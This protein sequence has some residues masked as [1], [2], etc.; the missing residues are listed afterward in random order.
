MSN[1]N[2]SCKVFRVIAALSVALISLTMV[3]AQSPQSESAANSSGKAATH[4]TEIITLGAGCFWCTEAVFQQI[5]GVTSVKPGYMGG[6][7]KNP[8]YDDICTGTTG[9]A[10]VAQLSFDPQKVTLERILEIFWQA[11]DPTQL[12]RQGADVGTQYRSA[13]FYENDTQKQIAEKSKAA[14]QKEFTKPIVTEITKAATFY[15]AENYHHDYYRRNKDKN[16]YC[17]VVI[18]P[19]LKKL[20]LQE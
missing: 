5:A 12:N 16:P 17:Q 4:K 3:Q 13:I 9:H 14:A 1:Q 15:V 10:E 20:G 6:K 19:K 11:H 2:R 18:A 7:T 8:T